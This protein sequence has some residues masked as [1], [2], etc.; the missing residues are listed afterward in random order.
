MAG[1]YSKSIVEGESPQYAYAL[2]ILSGGIAYIAPQLGTPVAAWLFYALPA[3]LFGFIW[4]DRGLRWG[5]L[6]CLPLISLIFFDMLGTG[7]IGGILSHGTI[8]VKA[9]S[10]ACLGAYVGSKLSVRNIAKRFPKRQVNSKKL[11]SN[12]RSAQS[13]LALKELAAPRASVETVLSSQSSGG[14]VQALEPVNHF[15]GLDAAL[16]KATQE[17]DLNRI[18]LLIADGAD[19]NAK[20][21]DEWLPLMY[22]ALDASN[23]TGW[24]ALMIATIE[25]HV[26]VVRVLLEYGAEVSAENN[27]GWTALRFA[28]SMDET[29]I[30]YMLL[31]AGAEANIADHEGKT[32]LMQAAGENIEG[33]LKALLD[34][35][36]NPQ[37]ADNKGQTALMIAQKHGPTKIIKILKKAEAQ[38]SNDIDAPVNI[39][40]DDNPKATDKTHRVIKIPRDPF[41]GLIDNYDVIPREA[42]L[43]SRCEETG[44]EGNEEDCRDYA[45]KNNIDEPSELGWWLVFK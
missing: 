18:K 23:D 19:V 45:W 24:T 2:A 17:G 12:G 31:A 16:I 6:L 41:Y 43:P 36:A 20:S 38:A 29:E 4:P 27:R 13:G 9:L 25:G 14:H 3:A 34:A 33:S 8:L 7:L 37:L 21:R 30:L 11:K 28:V 10:S 22:A 1:T 35:G 44:H 5:G 40:Q 15:H 26:D 32:A 39:P 42:A